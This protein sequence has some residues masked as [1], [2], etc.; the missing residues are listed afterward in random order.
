VEVWKKGVCSDTFHPRFRSQAMRERLSG[1]NPEAPILLSVGRLG[2]EKNL[3]FLRVGGRDRRGWAGRVG[4]W[5]RLGNVGAVVV[6]WPGCYAIVPCWTSQVQSCGGVATTRSQTAP[7]AS[8]PAAHTVPRPPLSL[9]H[10]CLLLLLLQDILER[11]PG[12]RLAFVGDGP[13]REELKAYFAGTPTVFTGMLHGEELS[14]AY[15]SADVFVM[16]S[17]TETLGE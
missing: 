16:P 17:E 3:K 7:F 13:A 4:A 6:F 1:G 12:A 5:V 10:P 15:A 9:R 8:G 2:N 14:A 11:V